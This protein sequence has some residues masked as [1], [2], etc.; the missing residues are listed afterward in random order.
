MKVDDASVTMS[1]E[2]ERMKNLREQSFNLLG[3]RHYHLFVNG[4]SLLKITSDSM[5]NGTI[6][7]KDFLG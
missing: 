7:E 5:I 4:L 2:K 6:L 1:L 3:K